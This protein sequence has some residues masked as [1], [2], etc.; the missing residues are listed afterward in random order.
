M[1]VETPIH[2][3]RVFPPRQRHPV[4]PTVTGRTS[5]SLVNVNT[6]IEIDETGE[7]VHAR[8]L[9]RPIRP[10]TFAHRLE[11]RTVGPDLRMAIHAG[12][13]RRDAREGTFFDRSMAI[14]AIDTFVADVMFV[15][16][17]DGLAARHTDISNIR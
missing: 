8:P 7:I 15:A 3:E 14:A 10:K 1:T 17:W 5:D 9:N 12:L 11:H 13:G 16:E 4:D 2:V 6:V